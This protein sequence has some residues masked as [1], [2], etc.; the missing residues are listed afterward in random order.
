[1]IIIT[2]SAFLININVTNLSSHCCLI[3]TVKITSNMIV[4]TR[5]LQSKTNDYGNLMRACQ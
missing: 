2:I 4:Y 3:V 1:M 5:A